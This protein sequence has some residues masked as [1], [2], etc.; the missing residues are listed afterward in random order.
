MLAAR[1]DEQLVE[2]DVPASTWP[3]PPSAP[4]ATITLSAHDEARLDLPYQLLIDLGLLRR[5]RLAK[6]ALQGEEE[7]GKDAIWERT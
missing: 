2:D 5:A 3:Q 4:L 6:A 1:A 7:V